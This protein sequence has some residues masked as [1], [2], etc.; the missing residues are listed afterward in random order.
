MRYLYPLY[1]LVFL[2]SLKTLKS[3]SSV[4]D[5]VGAIAVCQNIYVQNSS[6]SG[7]GNFPNEITGGCLIEGEVNDVWYIV[8]VSSPGNLNFIISIAV[9]RSFFSQVELQL[10]R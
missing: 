4:Q 8:Q 1:F 6:F 9:I 3:Q 2:T 7:E 10:F 5:C